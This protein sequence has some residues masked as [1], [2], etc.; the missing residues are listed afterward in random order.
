M[1][2]D[3]GLLP[4]SQEV[5]YSVLSV[6]C[7]CRFLEMIGSLPRKL[8]AVPEY[9]LPSVTQMFVHLM[10]FQDPTFLKAASVVQAL[11]PQSTNRTFRSH[12]WPPG[13]IQAYQVHF[14]KILIL[15]KLWKQ[16]NLQLQM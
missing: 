16:Q 7:G 8:Y 13:S 12:R 15:P 1:L 4:F 2:Q 14:H 5:E 6:P 3:G 10:G 11:G 9:R